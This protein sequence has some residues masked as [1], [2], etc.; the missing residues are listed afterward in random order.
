MGEKKRKT[1]HTTQHTND[2]RMT[3][4]VNVRENSANNNKI[5]YTTIG[6]RNSFL[7]IEI[8]VH[9]HTLSTTATA[10]TTTTMSAW[11]S[12]TRTPACMHTLT[13]TRHDDDGKTKAK[14]LKTQKDKP[15]T[16][17]KCTQN[18]NR[19]QEYVHRGSID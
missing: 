7:L 10:M 17:K 3:K 12:H 6:E 15:A 14:L 11:R 5:K 1:T 19:R 8:R 18:A 2:E 13:S 16:Q 9:L 4:A